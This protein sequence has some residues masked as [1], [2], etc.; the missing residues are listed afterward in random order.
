M[1]DH[2]TP[3][4]AGPEPILYCLVDKDGTPPWGRDW[5]VSETRDGLDVNEDEGEDSIACYPESVIDALSVKLRRA[6]ERAAEAE[7]EL[8]EERKYN[9]SVGEHELV[10]AEKSRADRLSRQLE[11]VRKQLITANLS[12]ESLQRQLDE[13]DAP[14]PEDKPAGRA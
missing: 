7:R 11:E 2:P 1:T 12:R 4:D 3:A 6:E 8:R 5:I 10:I 14:S 9:A 13:V